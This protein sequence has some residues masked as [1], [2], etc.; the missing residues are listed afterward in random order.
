MTH[1]RD[2]QETGDSD[3]ARAGWL[4]VTAGAYE[5]ISPPPCRPQRGRCCSGIAGLLFAAFRTEHRAIRA[6]LASE[7]GH[8]SAGMRFEL[9]VATVLPGESDRIRHEKICPLQYDPAAAG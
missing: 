3:S 5:A 2:V 8:L 7:T 6:V 1:R 4:L 9:L